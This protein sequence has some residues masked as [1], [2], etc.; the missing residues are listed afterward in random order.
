MSLPAIRAALETALA[1]MSPALA[2]AYENV[3]FEPVQG[4]PHQRVYV[5]CTE[6]AMLEMSGHWHREQGFMQVTLCYPLG[7]GPN[8]ATAR[9]ELIR[10][11][12]YASAEFTSGGIVVRVD[13]TPEIAPAIIE[14]DLYTIPVRVRF[15]AHVLRT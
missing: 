8:A 4:T 14:D 15:Y 11:T 3:P 9:A 12:F 1:G 5:L 10:S 7:S 6:P 13:G 2:T